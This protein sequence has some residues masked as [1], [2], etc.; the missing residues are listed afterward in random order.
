LRQIR[1]REYGDRGVGTLPLGAS[2]A[3]RRKTDDSG[4]RD[5]YVWEISIA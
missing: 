2:R 1:L 3:K 5:L 4:F